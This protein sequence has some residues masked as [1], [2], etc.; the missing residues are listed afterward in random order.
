[1][2][3]LKPDSSNENDDYL[4]FY[5]DD[6]LKDQISGEVDFVQSVQR[7]PDLRY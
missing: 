6:T 3:R 1:M 7:G 4:Q 5:I 2:V